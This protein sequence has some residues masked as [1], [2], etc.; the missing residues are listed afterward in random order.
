MER[1]YDKKSHK[2]KQRKSDNGQHKTQKQVF[3]AVAAKT[4]I[5]GHE[6]MMS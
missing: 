1:R 3:L 4:F 6:L 5:R 2:I